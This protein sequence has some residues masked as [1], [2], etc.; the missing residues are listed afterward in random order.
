M[1]FRSRPLLSIVVF[2]VPLLSMAAPPPASPFIARAVAS[3]SRLPEDRARDPSSRP[4][5]VL[6]FL[7]L[8]P[9]MTVLDLNAATGYYTEILARA[10]GPRGRVIA[11]NH[12]GAIPMLGA[13]MTARYERN[14][15][16]NVTSLI[17]RH[18]ELRPAAGSLDMVLMSMTYHDTYW[19]DARV[20]WG[21][22]DQQSLLRAFYLALKPGGVVGVIDH[23]AEGATNP[24]STAKA[25][26]RIDP[27]VVKRDFRL[28]GFV[29]EAESDV[30]RNTEDDH[31]RGVFDPA[32]QGRTDRF[33]YRFRKPSE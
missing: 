24:E 11:E 13:A 6:T 27:E 1:S 17:A 7:G 15:L 10:V 4:A 28:A 9:G 29:L 32:I 33:V 3:G 2:G 8:Q 16:P 25:L 31:R 26:H 19:Y 18:D 5:E 12:P 20:D 23:I 21:P 30:L 14:R 22:V